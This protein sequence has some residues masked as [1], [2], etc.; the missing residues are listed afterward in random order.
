MPRSQQD[1]G[2]LSEIWE[3][4][5]PLQPSCL[6]SKWGRKIAKK[7]HII[8]VQGVLQRGLGNHG[9]HT[10]R[11]SPFMQILNHSQIQSACDFIALSLL[12]S[13]VLTWGSM[14]KRK[15]TFSWNGPSEHQHCLPIPIALGTLQPKQPYPECC[16]GPETTQSFPNESLPPVP[17]NLHQHL[18]FDVTL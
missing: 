2:V 6:N 15:E 1:P 17:F 4:L 5:V 11:D 18:L 3:G 14:V 16:S 9:M 7:K 10:V 8:C 12:A 13:A